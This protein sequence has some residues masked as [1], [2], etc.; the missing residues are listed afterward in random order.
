MFELRTYQWNTADEND[1]KNEPLE[2]FVFHYVETDLAKLDPHSTK[3]GPSH[4][5][6]TTDPAMHKGIYARFSRH[7]NIIC[8]GIILKYILKTYWIQ[9]T[10]ELFF[11]QSNL[12]CFYE[13]FFWADS[14]F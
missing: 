7:Y 10:G 11:V 9:L 8:T 5:V 3:A 4:R 1:H 13:H 14:S 6:A 2:Q 12:R